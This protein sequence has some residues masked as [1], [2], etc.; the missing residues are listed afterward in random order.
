MS[1]ENDDYIVAGVGLVGC[2]FANRLSANPNIR[3]LL[4]EAGRPNSNPR[5]DIPVGYFKTL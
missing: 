2:V 5:I 4:L 3:V 1:T